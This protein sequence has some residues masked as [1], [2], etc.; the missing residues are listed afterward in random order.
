MSL[1]QVDLSFSA[2]PTLVVLGRDL[3]LERK[4]RE[5]LAPLDVGELSRSLRVEWNARLFSAA[6]RA[7]FRRQLISGP[8]G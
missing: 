2:A 6:G 5:L 1:K 8:P 3:E 4:A 7:V